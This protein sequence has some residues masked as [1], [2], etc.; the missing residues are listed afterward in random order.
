[1]KGRRDA[2]TEFYL[3]LSSEVLKTPEQARFFYFA[4]IS[5][6]AATGCGPF[7]ANCLS[8][9]MQQIDLGGI[10]SWLSF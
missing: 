1:M 4:M 3:P 5:F 9:F 7:A 8:Q 10:F 2:I 6:F